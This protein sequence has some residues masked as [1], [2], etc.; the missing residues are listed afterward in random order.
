MGQPGINDYCHRNKVSEW[1]NWELMTT[2]IGNLWRIGYGCRFRFMVLNATF[3]NISVISWQSDLLVVETTLQ[4][5]G[6]VAPL[7]HIIRFQPNQ[8]CSYS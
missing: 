6:H 5:K 7:V 4:Y 2:A 1:D 3:N 8:S